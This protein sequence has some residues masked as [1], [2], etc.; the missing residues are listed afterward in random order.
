MESH[1]GRLFTAELVDLIACMNQHVSAAVEN[2][3]LY[4]GTA[5]QLMEMKALHLSL[6]HI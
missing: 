6:I 4:A 5:W 1:S 2:T 3:Q